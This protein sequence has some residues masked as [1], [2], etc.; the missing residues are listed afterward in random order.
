MNSSKIAAACLLATMLALPGCLFQ[1][2]NTAHKNWVTELNEMSSGKESLPL[3][4]SCIPK[5]GDGVPTTAATYR[6][7]YSELKNAP[8]KVNDSIELKHDLVAKVGIMKQNQVSGLGIA[9]VFTLLIIPGYVENTLEVNVDIVGGDGNVLRRYRRSTDYN[10]WIG[11][12]FFMWGPIA[13]NMT[14]DGDVITDMSRDIV[15]EMYEKDYAFYRDYRG[16]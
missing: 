14:A 4:V 10:L 12:I 11:W 7:V 6:L 3:V 5:L 9:S 15:K 1:V 13:S 2:T 8:F 16:K